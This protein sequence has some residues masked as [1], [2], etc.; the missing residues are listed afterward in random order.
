[1]GAKS[2]KENETGQVKETVEKREKT[3]KIKYRRRAFPVWLRII[4]VI[5]LA[6]VALA[7]GLMVG[8]GVIGNGEAMDVFKK[9]TWQHIIDIVNKEK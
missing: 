6:G 2:L 4:V 7:L 8:Y 3:R 9:D 1:M 5:V